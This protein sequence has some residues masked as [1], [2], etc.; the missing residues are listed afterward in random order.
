MPLTERRPPPCTA[1]MLSAARATSSA[2][3]LENA[4]SGDS[5]MSKLSWAMTWPRYGTGGSPPLLAGWPGSGA[6]IICR[7]L[8]SGPALVRLMVMPR[9]TGSGANEGSFDVCRRR[10]LAIP[11]DAR[12]ARGADFRAE[13]GRGPDGGARRRRPAGHEGALRPPSA[14]RL[15]VRAAAR[16]QRRHRRGHCERGLSRAVAPCGELRGPLATVDLHP[17]HRPQQGDLG[18]AGSERRAAR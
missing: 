2:A 11:A 18:A 7:A 4:V 16:W 8:S 17:H 3:W 6:K 10:S 5:V 15:P 1:T 9:P 13:H 12:H 14:R